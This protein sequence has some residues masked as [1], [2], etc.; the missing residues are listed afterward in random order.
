MSTIKIGKRRVAVMDL[1]DT[2]PKVS[3]VVCPICLTWYGFR[4]PGEQCGDLSQNQ[5]ARCVGR[6]IPEVE[7]RRAGWRKEPE[8]TA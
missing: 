2:F 5:V 7:F 6:L 4:K 8:V 1:R 3:E